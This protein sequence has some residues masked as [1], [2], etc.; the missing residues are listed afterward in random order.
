MS[1][2]LSR[3]AFDAAICAAGIGLAACSGPEKAQATAKP[4]FSVAERNF[5]TEAQKA[6]TQELDLGNFVK[7]KSK[8][9]EIRSYA[10]TVIKDEND[11]L[12]KL[13]TIMQKYQ[14]TSASEAQAQAV[15]ADFKGLSRKALDRKFVSLAVENDQK[16]IAMLQEEANS[17]ANGDLKEYAGAELAAFQ[18][19]LKRAENLQKKMPEARKT[20]HAGPSKKKS[21]AAHTA[22][23]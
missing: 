7:Q 2:V 22:S 6:S 12:Q 16:A 14:M 13:G 15:P 4:E 23:F 18:S 21:A 19:D 10:D 20:A 11:A 3:I 9:K 8:D 17:G 5:V 1:S